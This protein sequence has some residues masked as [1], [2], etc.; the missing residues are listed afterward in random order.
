MK[1]K[2]KK[3]RRNNGQGSNQ[4]QYTKIS[5]AKNVQSHLLRKRAILRSN[6]S[7]NLMLHHSHRYCQYHTIHYVTIANVIEK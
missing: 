7:P 6:L 4:K 5:N 2:R 3:T 1:Y